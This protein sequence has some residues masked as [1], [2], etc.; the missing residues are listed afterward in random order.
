[1]EVSVS[2]YYAWRK[3]L[4]KP[5]CLKRKKLADLI[6]D[7]YWENRKRYGTRRIKAALAKSGV[8]VGRLLVRKM[9]REQGLKAMQPK[10]FQP[11]TTDSRGTKASPNL[12]TGVKVEECAAGKVI[13]G[14]ITYLP[15]RNGKWCYLAMWQDKLTRR[16]IGWSVAETMTAEL[17]ISALQ[18]AAHKGLAK[19]GALI[20]SD[21][22]SQ[23]AATAF[24]E[25]L[26]INGF[27]QSMS[28]KG[29]GSR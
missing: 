2:G 24:R 29:K 21:R 15:L 20:H 6:K 27:C 4:R 12:L 25:L 26:R 16:I 11:K 19:A 23:Y 7:C 28:G 14:D 22:G 5:P 8:K 18:K 17:V 3:R 10:S 1:M 13:V 9:M